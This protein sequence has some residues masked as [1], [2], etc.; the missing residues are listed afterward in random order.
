MISTTVVAF[1]A[2]E[3]GSKPPL[4]ARIPMVARAH[5]ARENMP[6]RGNHRDYQGGSTTA[7][8]AAVRARGRDPHDLEVSAAAPRSWMSSAVT[9][10]DVR[11]ST[12]A[13]ACVA[14][15][16]GSIPTFPAFVSGEASGI[17]PARAGATT[18]TTHADRTACTPQVV[19]LRMRSPRVVATLAACSS[20]LPLTSCAAPATE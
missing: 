16:L 15:K 17:A 6:I 14:E 3:S 10:P 8:I 11:A 13:V 7:I 5:S 19:D 20:P 12:A 4:G 1:A 18:C 2:E 9:A